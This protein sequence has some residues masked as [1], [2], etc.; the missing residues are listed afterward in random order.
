L[1]A[2]YLLGLSGPSVADTTEDGALP[3]PSKPNADSDQ[4][5]AETPADGL[6]ADVQ[7]RDDDIVDGDA[8][9]H[10]EALLFGPLA[11]AQATA[12]AE[13]LPLELVGQ[14]LRLSGTVTIGF[15]RRLSDFVNTNEGLIQLR[16]VTVLRRNGDPTKVTS[17]SIW[18]NPDE[19]TLIGQAT[20][21]DERETTGL[22]FMEKRPFHLI[23]VTPG[24]TLTGDVHLSPEAILSA[25]LE[26]RS[27]VW[28]PM[29]DV[30]TRSLA[31]RRV[32]SR[33]GFAL[34]NRR[35]IVAATELEPG[36][37]RG[38]GVL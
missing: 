11:S 6:T 20:D 36:T 18:V 21:I 29:T 12:V 31:D 9:T 14:H 37:V 17:P 25:F 22:E 35:H 26:S 27:P 30:Q 7:D 32:I 5:L 19:V 4:L 10:L 1:A 38:R 24:H 2:G 16:D 33:Y 8:A 34:V 3:P 15:H 23:V 28:I 13:G